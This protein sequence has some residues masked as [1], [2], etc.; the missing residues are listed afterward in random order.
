MSNLSTGDW[1][2]LAILVVACLANLTGAAYGGVAVALVWAVLAVLFARWR[3]GK[4][5]RE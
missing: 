2:V 5:A 4:H 1:I 3:I